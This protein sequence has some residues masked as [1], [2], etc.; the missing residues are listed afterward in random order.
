V[1]LASIIIPVYNGE[2]YIHR[3]IECALSQTY[4]HKEVIVIDDASTDRTQEVV[5]KYPVIYHRNERNMERAYS[6]NKGVEL[7]KGEFI[8]FLDHDDLWRED[9]V[10]SVLRHLEDSQIVYS[11]PRSFINSEGNLLRVSRKKLPED[12]LEL[13]FSGMVGYPSATAFKRSAFLGYKDE[14][15]MREDWEIFLRSYLEGLSLKILD[16]DK[17]FIREHPKRTS[18]SKKFWI[19]T[20]KVYEDYKDKVPEEYIPYFLFHVGETAMRF[21]ELRLGWELCTRAIFKKPSLLA[22]SRRLWSLLKRGFRFW[23]R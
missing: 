16:E 5:K 9:Y 1:S 15:V 13:V 4:P 3:A 8:F 22:N 7:S 18:R 17:V 20:Y 11:F 23:R 10:E 2:E 21:G 19:A 14:Y 12:P 6:R